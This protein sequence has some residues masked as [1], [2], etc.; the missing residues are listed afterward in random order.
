MRLCRSDLSTYARVAG[1]DFPIAGKKAM[2]NMATSEKLSPIA[3]TWSPQH[4]G[5]N[6][7]SCCI[8]RCNLDPEFMLQS[9]RRQHREIAVTTT[10]L[11]LDLQLKK[12]LNGATGV[13]N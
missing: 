7:V 12:R 9:K 5:G 4:V 3:T 10:L 1:G 8:S 2:V 13:D 6:P 11:N